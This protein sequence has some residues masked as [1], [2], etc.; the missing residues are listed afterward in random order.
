[1]KGFGVLNDN[2]LDQATA[3]F[4]A[5]RHLYMDAGGNVVEADDPKKQTLLVAKGNKITYDRARALGLM[6]TAESEEGEKKF[7]S[8]FKG[9]KGMAEEKAME[10]DRTDEP[11]ENPQSQENTEDSEEEEEE[12]EEEDEESEGMG[13][14][15]KQVR[16][17]EKPASSRIEDKQARRGHRG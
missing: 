1:M 14:E 3:G 7:N 15:E 13:V 17:Q 9:M 5:D 10:R 4:V 16:R 8:L 11:Q 6:P 12:S 2:Q